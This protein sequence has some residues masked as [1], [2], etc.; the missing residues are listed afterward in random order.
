MVS[1]MNKKSKM[2]LNSVIGILLAFVAIIG[3]QML[4][5]GHAGSLLQAAAFLIVMNGTTGAVLLQNPIKIF[6]NGIKMSTWTFFH[7]ITRR[8]L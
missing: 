6:L 3:G 7:P 8:K 2:D 5:G 1:S 4:E